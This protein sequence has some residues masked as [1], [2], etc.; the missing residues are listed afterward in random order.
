MPLFMTQML[1]F[2]VIGACSFGHQ[3][4]TTNIFGFKEPILAFSE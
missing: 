2:D 1:F 3:L 4:L